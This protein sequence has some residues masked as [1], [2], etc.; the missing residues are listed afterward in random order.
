MVIYNSGVASIFEVPTKDVRDVFFH[1]VGVLKDILKLDYDLLHTP[2][3]LLRCEWL[4]KTD[5]RGNSMYVQDQAGFLLV[6]SLH[7]L[8]RML[9]PFNIFKSGYPSVLLRGQ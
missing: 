2:V 1:Y 3:I 8:P 6:N 9:D 7:K 4:K 5:N